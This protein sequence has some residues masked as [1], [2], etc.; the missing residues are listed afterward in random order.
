MSLTAEQNEELT[1][2]LQALRAEMDALNDWEKGFIGDMCERHD[3][4]GP[5]TYV[6]TKQWA[7]LRGIYN[8]VVGH[9]ESEPRGIDDDIPF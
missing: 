2:M 6:S 5:E 1:D 8:N 4:Y 7:K 9:G 3:K